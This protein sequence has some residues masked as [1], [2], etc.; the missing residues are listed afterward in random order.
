MLESKSYFLLRTSFLS[1]FQD[2]W[3]FWLL[4]RNYFIMNLHVLSK[5][6]IYIWIDISWKIFF[7]GN[8]CVKRK[9][10]LFLTILCLLELGL[11][12]CCIFRNCIMGVLSTCCYQ[13]WSW[14]LRVQMRSKSVL[15]KHGKFWLTTLPQTMVRELLDNVKET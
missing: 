12:K 6:G 13:S 5:H 14:L 2:F 4:L 7:C 11:Q 3:I 9:L 8:R 10:S 15:S 1:C